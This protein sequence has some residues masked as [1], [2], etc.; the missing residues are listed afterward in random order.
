MGTIKS[1]VTRVV[2]LVTGTNMARRKKESQKNTAQSLVLDAIKDGP[3][4]R[5]EVLEATLLSDDTLTMVVRDLVG[6]DLIRKVLTP[7]GE[8]NK[9]ELVPRANQDPAPVEV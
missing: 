2:A 9:I 4:T 5:P 3:K 6:Q 7:E 1:I 8:L